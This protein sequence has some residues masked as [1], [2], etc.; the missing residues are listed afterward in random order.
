MTDLLQGKQ[1][2]LLTQHGKEAVLKPALDTVFGCSV[3]HVTGLDL[4]AEVVNGLNAGRS[5]VDDLSAADIQAMLSAG[6]TASTDSSVLDEADVA[7]ICVPTPLSEEG[8]PEE[9]RI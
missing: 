8:G 2:A 1:I 4:N 9:L 7:V 5:H 3:I 6:F